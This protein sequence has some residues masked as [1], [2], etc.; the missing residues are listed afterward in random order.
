MH[1]D[2][3][4]NN[5]LVDSQ[6][7]V[8]LID[9][10]FAKMCANTDEPEFRV[11]RT[12]STTRSMAGRDSLI[13]FVQGTSL[14]MA[15][16]VDTQRYFFEPGRGPSKSIVKALSRRFPL[17]D[18]DD[19]P[20]ETGPDLDKV[21]VVLGP[22]PAFHY[23]PLHDLES[24]WW[25]SS[26]VMFDLADKHLAK[27]KSTRGAEQHYDLSVLFENWNSRY[28]VM[29]TTGNFA[30]YVYVLPEYLRPAGAALEKFRRELTARYERTEVDLEAMSKPAFDGLH[31]LLADAMRTVGQVFT[32]AKKE[33]K[34]LATQSTK[35]MRDRS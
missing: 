33:Q 16:E 6:G 5:I 12:I 2:I 34:L 14:F 10:E 17:L 23:N 29:T 7:R 27:Q 28:N 1:R 20:G 3:S 25:L 15:L 8:R 11:V 13:G 32:K 9:F 19:E 35:R 4:Y 21:R 30:C 18:G 26:W 24:L 31:E 22:L